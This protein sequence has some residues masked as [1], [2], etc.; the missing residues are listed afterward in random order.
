MPKLNITELNT[1]E[2]NIAALIKEHGFIIH[3]EISTNQVPII[4]T[5]GIAQTLTHPDLEIKYP[6]SES[7]AHQILAEFYYRIKDGKPL[8]DNE[9]VFGILY[10]L[11]LKTVLRRDKVGEPIFRILLPDPNGRFPGDPFCEV[12]YSLQE[13]EE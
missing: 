2:P 11:P 8:I 1:V 12:N 9:L 10:K 3:H 5:Y 13:N 7:L 6:L 4:Y